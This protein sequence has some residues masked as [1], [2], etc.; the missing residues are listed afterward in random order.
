M[1]DEIFLV[2]IKQENETLILMTEH[3]DINVKRFLY[4]N[5]NNDLIV[6][7][8]SV[9]LLNEEIDSFKIMDE[10]YEKII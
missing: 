6:I 4:R 5:I 1:I 2:F 10:F 3:L 9:N 7:L 8:D